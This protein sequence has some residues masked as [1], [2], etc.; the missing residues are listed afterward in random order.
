MGVLRKVSTFRKEVKVPY[1]LE[2]K[3]GTEDVRFSAEFRYMDRAEVTALPKRLGAND[4]Q[5]LLDVVLVGV[6]DAKGEDGAP[7]DPKVAA[8]AVKADPWYCAATVKAWTDAITG[9]KGKN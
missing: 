3:S 7:M 4:E 1:P 9:E 2:G 8:E 5:H 6:H